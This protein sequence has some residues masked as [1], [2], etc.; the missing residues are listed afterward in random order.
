MSMALREEEGIN[1]WLMSK[2]S[3]T[4][5]IFSFLNQTLISL[6]LREESIHV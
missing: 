4:V 6:L 2:I 5:T 3:K 1:L